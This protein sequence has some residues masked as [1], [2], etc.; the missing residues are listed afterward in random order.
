MSSRILFQLLILTLPP[1]DILV[2]RRLDKLF[3]S[4]LLS[5]YFAIETDSHIAQTGLKRVVTHL[6]LSSARMTGICHH[7]QMT[8]IFTV[9]GFCFVLLHYKPTA[10]LRLLHVLAKVLYL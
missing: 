6:Q 3:H 1:L 4:I 9:F 2:S 5:I 8:G 10:D 7:A